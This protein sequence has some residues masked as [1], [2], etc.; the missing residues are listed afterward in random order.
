MPTT[1]QIENKIRERL[2]KMKLSERETYN[3]VLERVLEDIEEL[4]EQTKKELETARKQIKEGK[5]VTHEQVKKQY[6]IR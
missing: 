4:D 3:D 6:G 1:I 2:E 5:F